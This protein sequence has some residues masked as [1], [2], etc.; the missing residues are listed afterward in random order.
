MAIKD[1]DTLRILIHGT[2]HSLGIDFKKKVS[3]EK[4]LTSTRPHLKA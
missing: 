3:L 1:T 4:W 2:V